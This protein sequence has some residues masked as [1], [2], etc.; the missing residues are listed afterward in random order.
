MAASYDVSTSAMVPFA[1]IPAVGSAWNWDNLDSS[2]TEHMSCSAAQGGEDADDDTRVRSWSHRSLASQQTKRKF[3]F[4][5]RSS[6][7]KEHS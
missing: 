7:P 5:I 3:R 4:P 2:P 6:S 1:V